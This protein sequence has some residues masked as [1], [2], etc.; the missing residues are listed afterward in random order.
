MGHSLA[1]REDGGRGLAVRHAAAGGHDKGG[2]SSRGID[3]L[4][5]DL[6]RDVFRFAMPVAATGILEQLSNL[7]DTMMVG[8]LSGAMGTLGMAAVGANTPISSFVIGLF[9]GISLG[10]NVTIATAIGQGDQN[11]VSKAVH[12]SI[13]M[14]LAGFAIA[15]LGEVVAEPLLVL[16]R[17]PAETLPEAILFLRVY[18]L[19]MP[20]ILLYNFEAA[21]FRSIGITK[22]PLQALCLAAGTNV[23]FGYLFI[24]VFDWFVVGSALATVLCYVTSALVLLVRLLRIDA[25]IRVTPS[26]LRWDGPSAASI[27]HI[28]LPAGIQS[29]VFSLANIVIQSAINSLGT[30]VMAASSAS[31]SIEAVVYNLLNS[32]SQACTTFVGQNNG[33]RQLDR[34]RSV[35]KV[36]FAEASVAAAVV[37]LS[38]LAFGRQE[39]A[40]FNSDPKVV[41]I[42][43]VRVSIVI[44][45]YFFSMACE[46]ISGYLRGFGISVVP[47]IITTIVI[48]GIRFFWVLVVFPAN[49]TFH[50]IMVVYPISLATNALCMV[51][52]LLLARPAGKARRVAAR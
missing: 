18:L 44:S 39:I 2:G 29:A 28:G 49:P 16:L 35:L 25:P 13:L 7:I 31:L 48:C 21:I 17:V 34:C 32:F 12:T 15:L 33:A 45:S 19:A 6:R 24:G 36:S 5:G 1:Q 30:T 4:H 37:I 10:A 46:V 42:G 38:S 27:I 43:Y 50:T 51:A 23:V 3:I 8:R 9:V 14:A 40:L 11:R 26:R 20:A 41:E 47:A 22:L 52:V